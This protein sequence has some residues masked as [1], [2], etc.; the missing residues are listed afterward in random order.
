MDIEFRNLLVK[1]PLQEVIDQLYA[2][3]GFDDIAQS[4]ASSCVPLPRESRTM[5][6]REVA[7]TKMADEWS[8]EDESGDD[9]TE[10]AFADVELSDGG[11]IEAPD[12]DGTI[13]RRDVHGNLE[14]VLEPGSE[15]YAAIVKDYFPGYKPPAGDEEEE[16]ASSPTADQP[17]LPVH[18]TQCPV[19]IPANCPHQKR[20][21]AEFHPQA[22][23]GDLAAEADAEGPTQ[24][25]VTDAV[26]A[27][28]EQGARDIRDD[29]S[30]SDELR[31]GPGAPEW[32]REW[33]GP[34]YVTVE[35]SIREYFEN[36]TS[37]DEK[38]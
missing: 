32:I 38:Q 15:R 13:R 29:H 5:T 30:T 28:G 8:A 12:D 21:M 18:C 34:F 19:P 3:H 20:I 35:E 6:E 33:S 22:W 25:D 36:A 9:E 11:V 24:F 7:F 2:V 23:I 14:E 27:L 16:P 17:Q 10:S 26:L 4:L 31:S 37:S 1:A